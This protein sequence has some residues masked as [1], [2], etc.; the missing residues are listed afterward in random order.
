MLTLT[1]PYK[2]YT[3]VKVVDLRLGVR[4]KHLFAKF[5]YGDTVAGAWTPGALEPEEHVITNLEEITDGQ[6]TV[7][8]AADPAYD[9][10]MAAASPQVTFTDK[11]AD[12]DWTKLTVTHPTHGALDLWVE[13]S[14]VAVSRNLYQYAVGQGWYAGTVA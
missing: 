2:D 8:R 1:T 7:L 5:Q 13:L 14:Y 4:R 6:E 11:S 3:Q 12:P 10:L 9:L